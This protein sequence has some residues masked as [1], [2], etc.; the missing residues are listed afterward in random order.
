VQDELDTLKEGGDTSNS[1]QLALLAADNLF[2]F[3]PTI[4]TA[5]TAAEN[6]QAVADRAKETAGGCGAVTVSGTTVTAA[7][8][9][10]PGCT[11]A[12]GLVVSGT[13]TATVTAQS[14]MVAVALSFQDFTVEGTALTGTAS[15]VTSNG[16][17]FQVTLALTSSSGA[18]S[19]TVQVVGAAGAFTVDGPLTKQKDGS[20]SQTAFTALHYTVGG[21][22][23]D[24]GSVSVTKGKTKVVYQFSST[25]PT[26]GQ[27][28]ATVGKTTSTVTLP[29]YGSCPGTGSYGH[30]GK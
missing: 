22:Y 5:K 30:G 1:A 10:A 11:L 6:A 13:V 12:T 29:A 17:T 27:V 2:N 4:D 28:T 7:Y 14:G 23:P 20:T 24:G 19:G 8:G 21:C 26:T 15:L 16:S 9:P 25:T 3:D 18:V